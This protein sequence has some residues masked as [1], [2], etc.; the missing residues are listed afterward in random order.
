[1]NNL[2]S[3]RYILVHSHDSTIDS[4][5]PDP[6]SHCFG[7]FKNY[8]ALVAFDKTIPRDTCYRFAL[9]LVGPKQRDVSIMVMGL[10]AGARPAAISLPEREPKT[11]ETPVSRLIAEALNELFGKQ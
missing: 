9:P 4:S 8:E 2:P 10:R 7:P 6:V 5:G 11:E 1:M 3:P